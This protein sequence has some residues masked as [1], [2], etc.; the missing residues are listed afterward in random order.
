MEESFFCSGD[1]LYFHL[2]ADVLFDLLLHV[3]QLGLGVIHDILGDALGGR[4]VRCLQGAGG[5]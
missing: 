4:L 2:E 3:G 5:G 1:G